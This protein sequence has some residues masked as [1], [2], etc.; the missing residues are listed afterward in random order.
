MKRGS[1][2]GS[3][4]RANFVRPSCLTAT[5]RFLLRLEMCGNGC[6]GSNAS[7]VSTGAISRSKMAGEKRRE[8]VRVLGRF[9]EPD[10]VRRK[11]GPQRVG[12]ALGLLVEHLPRSRA[13][14][15]ELLLGRQPVGRDVLAVGAHLLL[16]HRHANHE[17]LVEV[18]PDDGEEL[19]AFEDRV[20]AV[21]RLVEHPLVEREPAELAVEIERR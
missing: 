13:H 3:L 7:G 1:T 9:E 20:P 6:P 14:Q 11:L 21:A 12:P 17:E 19:D 16:Q 8:V 18:G 15:R 10:A 4:M 2:G 5:A